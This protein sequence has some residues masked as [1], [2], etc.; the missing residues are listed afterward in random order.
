MVYT[1]ADEKEAIDKDNIVKDRTRGAAKQ[2][3]TEPGDEEVSEL[4][5]SSKDF[6]FLI[7]YRVYLRRLESRP[8]LHRS[9]S[10]DLNWKWIMNYFIVRT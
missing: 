9:S 6:L 7:F 1:E 2:D 3:Y 10:S 4:S 8:S 5:Y